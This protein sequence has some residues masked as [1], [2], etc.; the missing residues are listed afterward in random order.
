RAA[1][2][3]T[4]NAVSQQLAGKLD[5]DAL[6]DLVGEQVR[7]VFGADI[8]YVALLD[9]A[10][11]MVHFPYTYGEEVESRPL[12]EGLTSRIIETGEPVILNEEVVRRSAELGKRIVGKVSAAY[13][14]V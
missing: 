13:L 1:E 5:V 6:I 3:D 10:T 11:N 4:V 9:R 14:G 7:K 2:L 12:G 8:A